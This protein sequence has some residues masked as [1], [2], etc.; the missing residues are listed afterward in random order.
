MPVRGQCDE[1]DPLPAEIATLAALVFVLGLKHGLD[2]DHLVAIDGLTRGSRSRWS[3]LFFSLGHG[4]V[5]T[6]LGVALAL[7]A[8][9]WKVPGWLEHFGA[10]I[11]IAILLALGVANLFA[12]LRASQGKGPGPV[13]LRGRWLVSRI[14]GT[15]HPLV[16][17]C[18]GAAFAVSFDTVSHALV[19][20][21][22]GAAAAG[23]VFALALGLVFTLGMMFVDALNGW[24]VSRMVGA[25]A[26]SIAIA[27]LCFLIAF[28]GLARY[29]LPALGEPGD[30]AAPIFGLATLG[31]LGAAYL[32]GQRTLQST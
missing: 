31:V 30:V 20:S 22:T 2:P 7:F 11:S 9:D 27:A 32:L 4:F 26:M 12:A 21:V 29:A 24:C 25:R 14:S 19:F 28:V 8:L 6:L 5:V 18:I 1:S 17:A 15:T 16:I 10:W 3:G 13:G 23:W